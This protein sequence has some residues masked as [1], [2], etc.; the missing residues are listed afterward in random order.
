MAR[1]LASLTGDSAGW[2][3]VVRRDSQMG[4]YY[5]NRTA[6]SQFRDRLYAEVVTFTRV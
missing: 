4:S 2:C 6:H 5:R 1:Y 3:R